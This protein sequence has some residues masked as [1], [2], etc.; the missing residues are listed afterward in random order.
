MIL[1]W[2]TVFSTGAAQDPALAWSNYLFCLPPLHPLP[3]PHHSDIIL[4]SAVKCSALV[5]PSNAAELHHL[6][7]WFMA[8]C[9]SFFENLACVSRSSRL[10]EPLP[11]SLP[12]LPPKE[13]ESLQ[14][15]SY[16]NKKQSPGSIIAHNNFYSIKKTEQPNSCYMHWHQGEK[17]LLKQNQNICSWPCECI[18]LLNLSGDLQISGSFSELIV[19][20]IHSFT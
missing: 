11:P 12:P 19:C 9:I 20:L 5:I 17:K 7:F 3:R 1:P 10:D 15:I 16:P 6:T 2:A 13:K 18:T 14:W 4:D 8:N